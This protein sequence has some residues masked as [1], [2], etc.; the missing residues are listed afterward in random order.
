MAQAGACGDC[1]AS[2]VTISQTTARTATRR[3]VSVQCQRDCVDG[4]TTKSWKGKGWS[5]ACSAIGHSQ[6]GAAR[7]PARSLPG[8]PACSAIDWA[9]ARVLLWVITFGPQ[10]TSSLVHFSTTRT[11]AVVCRGRRGLKNQRSHHPKFSKNQR[12]C[13]DPRFLSQDC[14]QSIISASME[15]NAQGTTDPKEKPRRLFAARLKMNEPGGQ[16]RAARLSSIPRP[17]RSLTCPS[18]FPK[19]RCEGFLVAALGGGK[20]L[21]FPPLIPSHTV[22]TRRRLHR[23]PCKSIVRKRWQR[24]SLL[25]T[26][27]NEV[28]I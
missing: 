3:R 15:S 4:E 18:R 14:Q 28:G 12:Q 20:R 21:V 2:P 27:G 5:C 9:L 24:D 17:V 1:P 23:R 11:G 16:K 10:C 8:P 13:D 7:A 26:R 19:S 25:S 22:G 6:T